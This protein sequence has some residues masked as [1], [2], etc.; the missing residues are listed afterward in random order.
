MPPGW[1]LRAGR[2]AVCAGGFGA[3]SAGWGATYPPRPAEPAPNRAARSVPRRSLVPRT[4]AGAIRSTGAA[5]SSIRRTDRP[6]PAL[7]ALRRHRAPGR[8]HGRGAPARSSHCSAHRP[9]HDVGLG[10]G[11]RGCDLSRHDVRAG[12]GTVGPTPLAQRAPARVPRRSRRR[13]PAGDDRSHPFVAPGPRADHG[14]AHLARL[15]HRVGRHRR[16][17]HR[18]RDGRPPAHRRRARRSG[19]R[20]GSDRGVREHPPPVGRLLRCVVR[21]RSRHGSGA[22]RRRGAGC[23]SSPTR[24]AA[25]CSPTAC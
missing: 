23:R 6:A 14:R 19:H 10:R 12:H 25:P 7:V 15:R 17:D 16:P 13:R 1:H 22:R 4:R 5:A 9:R 3:G 20:G 18:R 2:C 8:G 24:P 21:T 11:G